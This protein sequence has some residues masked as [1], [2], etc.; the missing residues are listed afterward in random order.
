MKKP[1]ALGLRQCFLLLRTLWYPYFLSCTDLGLLVNKV[2]QMCFWEQ[3]NSRAACRWGMASLW[4]NMR[5]SF[6]TAFLVMTFAIFPLPSF[7]WCPDSF[8]ARYIIL[9]MVLW[10]M[11]S[12]ENWSKVNC[13]PWAL[14]FQIEFIHSLSRQLLLWHNFFNHFEI[15][16]K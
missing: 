7:L 11:F 10:G 6:S 1:T 15:Y 13:F 8:S 2:L 4:S 3:L 14:F 9:Y 12:A 5:L 16:L